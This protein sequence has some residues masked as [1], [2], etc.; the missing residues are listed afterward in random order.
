MNNNDMLIDNKYY[1]M[2]TDKK[3]AHVRMLSLEA[4]T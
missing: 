3:F 1:D 2:I 4:R